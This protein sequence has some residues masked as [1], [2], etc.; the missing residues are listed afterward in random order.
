MSGEQKG[1]YFS[2]K[3]I[4]QEKGEIDDVE[5]TVTGV[6]SVFHAENSPF[7]WISNIFRPKGYQSIGTTKKIKKVPTKIEP[8]VFFANERTFL[9]WLNM[10]VTLS[11]ISIGKETFD[12]STCIYKDVY[13]YRCIDMYKFV[14]T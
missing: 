6:E 8:K 2:S 12:M 11:S 3:S 14:F 9:A 1:P 10:S 5:L 4:P 13:V 7:S